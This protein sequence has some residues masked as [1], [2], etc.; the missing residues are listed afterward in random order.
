MPKKLVLVTTTFPLP[1]TGGFANK[2]YW[3]IKGLSDEFDIHLH[4]IQRKSISNEE[5]LGVRK[6]CKVVE[7]HSPN[8]FDYFFGLLFSALDDLPIQMGLF[9][10]F[11]AKK[12]ISEDLKTASVAV[13]SVIRG[14]QY[15]LKNS[16]PLVCDLADSLGQVYLNDADRF[17]GLKR[18]VYREEGR[19]MKKYEREVVE[20]SKKV[21]LFNNLEA[22]FYNKSNICVVPHG[23][24][25][26][27]FQVNEISPDYGDG[28]VFFGKMDYE[29]NVDAALWFIKNVLV[30]L[31][32]EIKMYIV[33]ANPDKR[34]INIASYS[35]RVIVTGFVEDPYPSIR[36][37]IAS[38]CPIQMGGGIQNKVIETLA[39]GALGVVS[40]KAASPLVDFQKT[41]LFL[42]D[43]P[44][45]WVQRITEIASN[46]NSYDINRQMGRNYA[47]NHFS[48]LAY[49][50][51]I[52]V[53][54]N[55]VI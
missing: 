28:I 11:K 13:C 32:P 24:N 6:Y 8:L 54:I 23:V 12:S 49:I 41:G 1:L 40:T 53:H 51:E 16:T 2:N 22:S 45:E 38:L 7:L 10:S 52:K 31:P 44:D 55:Q 20:K 21:F 18:L 34:I 25:P 37:A 19:R 9:F 47:K 4:V 15:L 36:G 39:V 33:G 42:C 43:T 17:S 30:R 5:Y 35:S 26:R 3:L 27:L 14:A 46:K 29:P 48:W 50:K